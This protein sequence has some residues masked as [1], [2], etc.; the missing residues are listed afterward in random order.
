MA[1][2]VLDIPTNVGPTSYSGLGAGYQDFSSGEV[3]P[4]LSK[5]LSGY[6]G[7]VNDAYSNASAGLGTLTK[8]TLTPAIQ[9]VINGLAG[10]NMINSSVAGD[11]MTGTI[12]NLTKDLFA[13]QTDMAQNKAKA[14]TT[15][16]GSLLTNTAGLGT[17]SASSDNSTA[18]KIMAQLLQ[19]LM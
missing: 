13:N 2:N 19:G 4:L 7:N 16:Y 15:D 8:N 14:L 18:Y 9:S 12:G 11:T 3:L 17:Y 1:T 10:K 6:K 5:L